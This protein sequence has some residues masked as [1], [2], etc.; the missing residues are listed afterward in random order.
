MQGLHDL[1]YKNNTVEVF[2]AVAQVLYT[3]HGLKILAYCYP[4]GFKTYRDQR[5]REVIPI[6]GLLSWVPNWAGGQPLPMQDRLTY[7]F[8]DRY[9]ASKLTSKSLSHSFVLDDTS[10]KV[11]GMEIDR[12]QTVIPYWDTSV[13]GLPWRAAMKRCWAPWTR[14]ILHLLGDSPVYPD[15]QEKI[16]TMFRTSSADTIRKTPSVSVLRRT[17]PE[18]KPLFEK[19]AREFHS[20]ESGQTSQA[21]SS[22]L[23]DFFLMIDKFLRH[24]R[25]IITQ[26]SYLGLGR[27]TYRPGDIACVLHTASTPYVLRSINE[28]G[29]Y[30]LVGEAYIHGYMDGECVPSSANNRTFKQV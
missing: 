11:E 10:L 14:Q 26:Q 23:R 30:S 5:N 29:E 27:P 20:I 25:V 4:I 3:E 8:L 1:S 9:S 21:P 18:D 6:K 2:K 16:N 13:T 24:K 28:D 17:G 19:I 7:R 15:L 12:I 22:Q